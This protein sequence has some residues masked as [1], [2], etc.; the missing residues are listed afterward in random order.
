[1][2]KVKSWRDWLKVHPAADLFP[3]MSQAEQL[4][5]GED[6]KQHGLKQPV[7]LWSPDETQHQVFVLDGRNRLDAMQAVG[8]EVIRKGKPGELVVHFR[9]LFGK[10]DSNSS[11]DGASIQ[12]DPYQFVISTNLHRRHLSAEQRRDLIQKLLKAAPTRSN[13]QIAQL[14]KTTHPTVAKV[15]AEMEVAGDVER[16]TTSTDTK[17]RHQPTKRSAIKS[18]AV[19]RTAPARTNALLSKWKIASEAERV[20]FVRV[21]REEILTSIMIADKEDDDAEALKVVPIRG[22]ARPKA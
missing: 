7:I 12:A 9:S 18:I 22:G 21:H 10:N 17:G 5:L 6:I 20:S 15:R 8:M 11:L 2:A 3:L 14:A 1:M 19:M 4:A 13:R 16:L